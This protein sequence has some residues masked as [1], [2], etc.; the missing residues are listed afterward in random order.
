[1]TVIIRRIDLDV[2]GFNFN[3]FISDISDGF[4]L[5]STLKDID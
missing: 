1:M 3:F 4:V 2:P 5:S